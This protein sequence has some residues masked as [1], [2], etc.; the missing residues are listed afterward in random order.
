MPP[1]E[2]KLNE[3]DR[4][5]CVEFDDMVMGRFSRNGTTGV[6]YTGLV[7][8]GRFFIGRCGDIAVRNWANDCGLDFTETPA[9][10][11]QHDEHDFVFHMRDG[12]DWTVDVKNSLNPR[13]RFMLV[14]TSQMNKYHH[15]IY[16]G[17]SG[18]DNGIT[19]SMKVWGYATHDEMVNDSE[20]KNFG[21]PSAAFR[22]DRMPWGM[23]N[24]ASKAKQ[25]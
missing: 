24:L 1:V 6:N 9:D 18:I 16:I 10:I 20:S 25:A 17:A 14:P 2:I 15:D 3:K 21:A 7:T 11:G 13:A 12:S 23:E 22:L 8:P 5:E 19:V 4:Q